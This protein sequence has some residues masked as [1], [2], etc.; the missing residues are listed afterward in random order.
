[1]SQGSRFG[2]GP[3][4]LANSNKLLMPSVNQWKIVKHFHNSTHLGRDSLFQLIP[5]LFMGK[6]FKILKQMT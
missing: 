6:L 4:W 2:P 3:L 1:M 5:Y